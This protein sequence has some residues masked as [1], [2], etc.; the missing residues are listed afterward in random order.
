MASSVIKKDSSKVTYINLGNCT[1]LGDA[2]DK[3]TVYDT[4]VIVRYARD[5]QHVVI[6]YKYANS[7]YGMAFGMPYYNTEIEIMSVVNGE[8]T[9][10]YIRIQS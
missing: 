6:M 4:P 3:L 1:S 2:W 9:A 8:K 7:L 5:G 10:E